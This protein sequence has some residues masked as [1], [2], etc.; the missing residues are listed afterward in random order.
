MTETGKKI[1]ELGRQSMTAMTQK[2]VA[3]LKVLLSDDLVYTRAMA[4][5]DTKRSLIEDIE[6]G[7]VVFEPMEPFDVKAKDFGNV[8]VLTGLTRT[9]IT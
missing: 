4:G 6:S 9:R 2:D 5:L 3:M 8:V 7:S 1:I